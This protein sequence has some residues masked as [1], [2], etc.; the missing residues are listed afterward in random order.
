[1]KNDIIKRV[2]DEAHYIINTEETIRNIAKI[3]GISKSTVHKDLNERLIEI[4]KELYD[5]VSYILK[6]HIDV[7][8][9]RGGESTRLK[10]LKLNKK[11]G[12]F[13][14]IKVSYT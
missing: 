6:K 1:M 3:Y 9:I 5:K 14:N 7:R 4:D 10:Y 8:H 2:V 11:K 12:T 13:E